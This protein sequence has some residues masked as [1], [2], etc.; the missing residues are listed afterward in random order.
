MSRSWNS[1]HEQEW[2]WSCLDQVVACLIGLDH[3]VNLL[4]RNKL[5]FIEVIIVFIV[6]NF[7]KNIVNML[8]LTALS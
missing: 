2:K 7:R 8:T 6:V 1:S 3:F 5:V 4:K